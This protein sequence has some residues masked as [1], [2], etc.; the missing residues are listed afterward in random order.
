MFSL[1]NTFLSV[2]L[3]LMCSCSKYLDKAPLDSVNTENY[4][5][6]EEDA[7]S[8]INGAY[9]P[10]QWPKLYN[11]RMWTTD[12]WAGNSVV[13]AGGGTDGIETQDIANF[14]TST[15]NAAAL[16]IWRGPAPG[17]LRANLVIQNVPAMDIRESIKNR[18]LGEAYFL[19]AH[20]YFILVQLFGD[21]P[22]IT[23]AQT[24]Q[25]DLR[26]A[27]NSSAE[28]YQLILSDLEKAVDL[29]PAKNEMA[30][31]DLGRATKGSA[32]GM[33]AKVQLTL[34]NYGETIRHCETLQTMGYAL[35]PQ[36]GD[37]FNP[38]SKN[39]VESLFE[40]QFMGKTN[41]GFWSNE[42]Q[43][44]WVSTFTGP[45]NADFVAGGY[46]W[47]QPTQEFVDAYEAGDLRKDQTI[48]Y[49]GGPEFDG[50]AYRSSYSATGYNLR[51]FL[52]DKTVS[53]D[54]DT[55]PANWVVLRYAD[56]LLMYAEALNET[57]KTAEAQAPAGSIS[58]GGPLNRV[59]LRAGL[60]PVQGLNQTQLREKILQER[61]MELAFEGH[62]WFDLIRVNQGA[63]G[64]SFLHSIGKVNATEKHLLLPI[65][66]KERD[67]NPN[68]TQ[69][70]GY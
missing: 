34:G 28:V 31:T 51:K 60:D 52:V 64:I 7:I 29:L 20:Y 43:S 11:L 58:T 13:G 37:N 63:Y 33:L 22:L 26:P 24:P 1:K 65:P 12:I 18:V 27:R 69:N 55:N 70:T 45:R 16:D 25:D 40:V 67:A 21:V 15:D 38:A 19:R 4:W 44:S 50:K 56:V 14:V 42:N 61:R 46:G 35:H 17:I 30:A 36:Y 23:T 39:G 41:F 10:L 5:K 66:Q 54:Y 6:T 9:Q 2:A 53:P 68:L 3:L 62:R 57:G 8:A 47:N 48:L 49:Q 32:L 59:R